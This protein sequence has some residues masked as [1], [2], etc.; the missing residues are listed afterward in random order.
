MK[1]DNS[2]NVWIGELDLKRDPEFME[3]ASNEFKD[4]P[5][6]EMLGEEGV[7][8]NQKSSRR[9]FLKFLGFG[10]GAAVVAAGCEIPV[11][12]AIPY[13]I[14]PEEIVP[15]LATYYASSFVRSGDYCSILVKTRDGRPIKIEGNESSEVTFGGT[16]ARAQAEVLN[17]YNTNR[18]KSPLKKEGDA[19]KQISWKE[20]DDEVMKGLKNGGSIRLVSHTNMSPSSSK[21]HSEFAASFADA[22]IVYYDPVSYAAVLRANELT[23]GQRALPEYRFELADLIVSFN[24]DFLGTWGSP[25]ENAHRFM[26]NRKPDDPKNAKMSRLVQF[27]SHMS[28]TGSNADNRILVKPSE[29]SSAAVALYNKVA[30][31]K[32]AGKIKALPLN[33]KAKKAI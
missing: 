1:K 3:N 29:Q 14:R 2:N 18:N 8:T 11:K 9:D 10:V 30:S 7:L 26:K 31:L 28:L 4:T 25:I 24:A 12:K 32:G 15:G 21:L 6:F 19:Y 27:E 16:S 33:E 13:V 23:V 22:K 17:L 20:L 5:L